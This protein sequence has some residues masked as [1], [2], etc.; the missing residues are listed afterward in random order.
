MHTYI[1]DQRVIAQHDDLKWEVIQEQE[2]GVP[3][4]V[5]IYKVKKDG[6]LV[7][8][9][10]FH[11]SDGIR[12][13]GIYR[14]GVRYCSWCETQP[15]GEVG[16]EHGGRFNTS[17]YCATFP[18]RR[19]YGARCQTVYARYSE[20]FNPRNPDYHFSTSS[21][22][23]KNEN[24]GRTLQRNNTTGFCSMRPECRKAYRASQRELLPVCK[25]ENCGRTLQTQQHLQDT[26]RKRPE[27]QKAYRDSQKDPLSACKNRTVEEHSGRD[28]TTG[29]CRK[30]PECQKAYRDSQKELLPLRVRTR[31]AGEPS[32]YAVT[33]TGYCSKAS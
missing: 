15:L 16:D 4:Q 32:G 28:N 21:K 30:R 33:L 31:T 24:C 27:C 1:T 26:V 18:K 3:V 5:H 19:T 2:N 25:N 20:I 7:L 17:G 14:D 13:P 9:F 12:I 6:S 10:K 8:W 23:C 29:Y 22:K 11:Y